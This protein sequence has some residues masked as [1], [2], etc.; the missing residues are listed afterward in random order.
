MFQVTHHPSSGAQNG[1]SSFWFC[2]R[3]RL[4]D[5]EVSASNNLS[6]Q[7]PLTYAKP[8]TASV[9]LSS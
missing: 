4:L 1:T 9:V 6:V 3:E 8:E 5:V 7:Q 2:L